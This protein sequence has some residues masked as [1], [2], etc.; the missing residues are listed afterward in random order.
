MRLGAVLVSSLVLTA[1]G[2]GGGGSDDPAET[3]LAA[4]PVNN[5][6]AA[7]TPV[8]TVTPTPATTLATPEPE[9]ETTPADNELTD[10]IDRE[11][12]SATPNLGRNLPDIGSSIAQLVKQLFFS[13]NLGGQ[14]DA[15]CVSCHHPVLGGADNLSL[16]V[17][18]DAVDV[19]NITDPELL[20]PGR[21]SVSAGNLPLVPRNA[22][23]V[24]NSGLW[25]EGM[26]WDSRVASLTGTP[27]R[28]G[29]SGGIVT[30]DSTGADATLP[31]GT[32]L[33]AAQARF[34]V[35]SEAE[36]RGTFEPGLDNQSLRATLAARLQG[37]TDWPALFTDAFGDDEIN[38]DRIA[39]AI[40]EY[41]RSMTFTN[42]PWSAYVAGDLGALTDQQKQGAILFFTPVNQGG[43]GC[44]RC[45]SGNGFTDSE[46]HA[47]GFP[48]ITDNRGRESISG[49]NGD[50]YHFRT[51]SLLNI[52]V[53][54]PYGHAGLYQTLEEVI[55][56]YDNPRQTVDNL[57]GEQGGQPF[58]N[59][60]A[61]FCQLPQ[62]ER[63]LEVTGDA[64]ENLFPDAFANSELALDRLQSNQ[65]N[66]DLGPTPNLNNEETAQL[67]AFLESLT[68]PCVVDRD[69]LNPWIV[70]ADDV[71]TY[72]D[73][74]ALLAH[75]ENKVDL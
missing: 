40:G 17:G 64:C 33:P 4:A 11:N 49:D 48:Q 53:T 59:A 35:T 36:M 25:D 6:A 2:G 37:A 18:V 63:I 43:A 44:N 1:C 8:A 3:T 62:I 16:S 12:L 9:T 51:P 29:A 7:P 30:P 28:N 10:I 26:F 71:A 56:H 52:A 54:A 72:P 46:H 41:E 75:D 31:A 15:A 65:N 74:S 24:F 38:Y 58:Q 14:R 13:K 66:S 32:T 34:P 20:G 19:F 23:T 47:V 21:H 67:V 60:N 45:H 27:N 5:T 73:D 42:S 55:D 69:C 57:F 50:R 70:D 68:D 39:E 61:D 22:P